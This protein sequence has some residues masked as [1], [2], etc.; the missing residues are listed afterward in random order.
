VQQLLFITQHEV[1]IDNAFLLQQH[2]APSYLHRRAK[3]F[4]NNQLGTGWGMSKHNCLVSY[5]YI[6][7]YY[8][9]LYYIISYL[10]E[11]LLAQYV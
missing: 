10:E 7:L 1:N 3:E 6:I 8:I 2:A 4:I 5:F 11:V 9:I